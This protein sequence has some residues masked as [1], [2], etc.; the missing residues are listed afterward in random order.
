RLWELTWCR[1]AYPTS[2]NPISIFYLFFFSSRRRHTILV[3][4]WSSD[5]CS[6]D[7]VF[8]DKHLSYSWDDAKWMYD[9]SRELGFPMMAGSSVRSEEHTSELQSLTN[10]VCRLLLEKKTILPSWPTMTITDSEHR[11]CPS[12]GSS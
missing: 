1:S 11:H 5:V 2:H 10:I 3:S 8:V 12:K 6:S 4:D 7:L 9:R